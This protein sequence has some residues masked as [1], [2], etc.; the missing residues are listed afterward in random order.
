MREQGYCTGCHYPI[1][2]ER[3]IRPVITE[4]PNSFTQAYY[5]P[6]DAPIMPT[7]STYEHTETIHFYAD[8]KEAIICPGCGGVL[9]T[10]DALT[11]RASMSLVRLAQSVE[12]LTL[13]SSA[14]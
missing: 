9:L 7:A 12:Q 6:T 11:D 13:P 5:L 3:I 4:F 14:H 2:R 1:E 8:G 10:G